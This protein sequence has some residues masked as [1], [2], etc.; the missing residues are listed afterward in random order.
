MDPALS[1]VQHVLPEKESIFRGPRPYRNYFKDHRGL[2]SSEG[3][4][5]LHVTICPDRAMLSVAQ[6]Q[7]LY[8]L[9][10]LSRSLSNYI[11]AASN[12]IPTRKWDIHGNVSVW[13]KFRI[14]LHSSFRSRYINCSQVV[15]ALPPSDHHPLGCCDAVLLSRPDGDD[16]TRNDKSF[17]F[18]PSF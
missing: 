4:V 12:G 18:I 5:A 15:Q 2:V 6:M 16:M 8:R 13:N 14:Q 17:L 1:F 9:P 11:H 10:D 3:A 7:A